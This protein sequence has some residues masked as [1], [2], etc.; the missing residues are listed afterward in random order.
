METTFHNHDGLTA[1]LYSRIDQYFNSN[2]IQK[3]GDWRLYSKTVLF[4]SILIGCY[5]SAILV[6]NIWLQILSWAAIGIAIPGI[7]FNTMHDAGHGAFSS[8]SWVNTLFGYSL[9]LIGGTIREWK[10]KHNLLHHH[11]TNVLGHDTDIELYPLIRIAK[12]QKRLWIHQFQ[13]GYCW[14][15]YFLQAFFWILFGD[16]KK[17]FSGKIGVKK[18][19]RYWYGH[20]IFWATKV[21]HATVFI[22]IPYYYTGWMGI[23]GYG[24]AMGLA[25]FI[26]ASVFQCA[27]VVE[28]IPIKAKDETPRGTDAMILHQIETTANFAPNNKLL[29][30]YVGGLNFQVEHHLFT[31][32]SHVHYKKISVIVQ[33]VCKDI[34]VRYHSIPTFFQALKSHALQLKTIGE[35]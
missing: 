17:Y 10:I 8:R 19:P 30:W 1:R 28:D 2:G 33:D 9:N 16:F 21:W 15:L 18:T 24:I 14:F 34:G 31:K 12:T 4:F 26:L 6:D 11:Q 13:H 22:F 25:G 3:T 32:I 7:G 27:H 5:L 35:A 20:I 23:I 29:S